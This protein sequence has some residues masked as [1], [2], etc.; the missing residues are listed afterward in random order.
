MQRDPVDACP[1]PHQT[2]RGVRTASVLQ[3]HQPVYAS[4]VGRWRNYEKFLGPL[5]DALAKG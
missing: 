4:S 3:V 1:S 5:L 2:R